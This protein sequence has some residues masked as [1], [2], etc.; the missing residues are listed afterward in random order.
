MMKHRATSGTWALGVGVLCGVFAACAGERI[1]TISGQLADDVETAYAG[2]AIAGEAGAAGASGSDDDGDEDTAGSGGSAAA[3]SAGAGGVDG[4]D[5]DEGGA[6]GSSMASAG[7]AGDGGGAAGAAGGGGGDEEPAPTCDGFA[8]L[9]ANCGT[10]GCHGDGSNL[11]IFAASE[12]DALT[13]IG[14]ESALCPGQGTLIDVENP[15]DSLLIRKLSDDPPC[16]QPMPAG[17]QLLAEEDIQCLRDWM[18][19]LE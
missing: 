17:G 4:D 13:Y 18:S 10:S 9:A 7:A 14:Q 11:G 12:E 5:G 2:G 1:P 3:A 19:N 15:D 6:A 8:I 16:G